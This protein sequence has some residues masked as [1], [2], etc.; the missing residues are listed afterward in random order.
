MQIALDYSPQPSP[1]EAQQPQ[2]PD[3]EILPYDTGEQLPEPTGHT[4]EVGGTRE[5][6]DCPFGAGDAKQR[7]QV[8]VD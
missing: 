5:M 6:G 4:P 3:I 2:E 8:E 7:D 1:G